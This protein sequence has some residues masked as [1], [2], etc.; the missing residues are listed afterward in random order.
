MKAAAGAVPPIPVLPSSWNATAILH[1]FSPPPTDDPQPTVPFYQMCIANVGFIQNYAL[2]VQITGLEYGTW[3]YWITQVETRVSTDQGVTWTVVNMG[4]SLPTTNWVNSTARFFVTYPLNWA[5]QQE[6]DWWTQPVPNSPAATW[7]WFNNGG[8]ANGLPYRLMFGA[9]PPSPAMGDPNQ[10]AVFQNFSFTYFPS[11]GAGQG[12]AMDNWTPPNIPGLAPGNPNGWDLFTWPSSLGMSVVMTPVDAASLPLPTNVYYEWQP[13]PQYRT[14]TDR[15]Q[16]TIM[17]YV[18]NPGQGLINEQACLYGYAPTGVNPP[19][20]AGL[21]FIYDVKQT[22][23]NKCCQL[24]AE[25]VPIG[26]EPPDW[27]ARGDGVI[28]ASIDY[29][30]ALGPGI[31]I[32]VIGV[33]FPPEP[34]YPQYP[35][36]RYLWTWYAPDPATNGQAAMPLTFMESAAGINVGTSLA[37]A[38]YNLY[39]PYS[40]PVPASLLALPSVCANV[41]QC[42]Q[43]APKASAVVKHAAPARARAT[44]S[45]PRPAGPPAGSAAT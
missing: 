1:P 3:W 39:V 9:P 43:A 42:G 8:P 7:F 11:F 10:L 25:G 5:V 40:Q 34:Q 19:P 30:P 16:R 41:G 27:P 26:Q 2:S 37:L 45:M 38:D 21:G 17:Y 14:L 23:P 13:D 32:I 15:A 31:P 12:T 24:Y 33:V 44:P 35:D 6:V 4:W 28:F 18:A 22:P 20:A 29:N 36:G